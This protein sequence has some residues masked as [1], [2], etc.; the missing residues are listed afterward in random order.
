[1][2]SYLLA[3]SNSTESDSLAIF[4]NKFKHFC[5]GGSRNFEKGRTKFPGRK[6]L[7]SRIDAVIDARIMGLLYNLFIYKNDFVIFFNH[8]VYYPYESTFHI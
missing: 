6:L 1:M 4:M 5:R 7:S 3:I 2:T 8:K